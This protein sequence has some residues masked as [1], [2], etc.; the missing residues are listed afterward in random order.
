MNTTISFPFTESADFALCKASQDKA[1]IASLAQANRLLSSAALQAPLGGAYDKTEV[2]IS[3]GP[4]GDRTTYTARVDLVRGM[5][6]MEDI[7]GDH[8][9]QTATWTQARLSALAS[10]DTTS[11]WANRQDELVELRHGAFFALGAL[12]FSP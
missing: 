10:G 11:L 2:R 8:L 12:T 1:E 3:W 7:I 4:E 6:G 9:R 5:A